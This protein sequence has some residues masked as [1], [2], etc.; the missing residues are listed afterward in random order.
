MSEA[1]DMSPTGAGG[2]HGEAKADPAAVESLLAAAKAHPL[3]LD[4]L[5]NGFLGSVAAT[6]GV[7]AFVVEEARRRLGDRPGGAKPKGFPGAVIGCECWARDGLQSMPVLVSTDHKVEMIERIVE[8]GFPK[9]EVT[10]FSHP[11]LLPQFADAEEVLKRIRRK[12]GTSYVVLMPNTRGFDRLEKCQGE[13]YGADEIILMISASAKHNKLNFRMDHEEAM[14]EHAAVMK[15]A[16]ALG[17]RVIGCAGTVYGCPVGGDITTAEVAKIVKFYLDEGAQTIMLGDTTGVANPRLVRDRV[18]ELMATYPKAEYIAHFHDTRGS[19]IANTLAA[20]E[21]GVRYVD[22]SIGAIGGQPATGAS[23]YSAGY[24]G[25]TCSED[26]IGVLEE[27]GIET[28]IDLEKLI[29]AGLRAE[30]IL[31]QR[32][33]SN[34]VRCGPVIHGE[35]SPDKEAGVKPKAAS[36]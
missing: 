32:L 20:L 14:A 1:M 8:A 21:L 10:S 22:C 18:G 15:R 30:E 36:A 28:G 3:G 29:D 5:A 33:R 16:H 26:L 12:A 31:G 24:T 4:Y 19:G 13:G 11:K 35:S 6:F 25:N 34:I 9:L 17:I 2:S 7:H 23:K 27:M